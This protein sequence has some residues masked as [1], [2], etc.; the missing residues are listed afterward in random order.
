[1]ENLTESELRGFVWILEKFI[2]KKR[3]KKKELKMK[4]AA[5]EI[6]GKA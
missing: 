4:I 6:A 3:E 5:N 1:M 2:K